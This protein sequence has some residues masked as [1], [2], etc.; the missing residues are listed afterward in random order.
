METLKM[1]KLA[2]RGYR[3][4]KTPEGHLVIHDVPIFVDCKRGDVE[5]D[6]VWVLQAVKAAQL[7]ADE[8]YLPP[9]H[10]YH[11]DS[12]PLVNSEVRAAGVIKVRGAEHIVFK[13][14]RRLA[15]MADLVVTDETVQDEVLAMKFPYRSVEILNINEP[16]INSLA[17]LDHQVPYLELPILQVKG[18]PMPGPSAV[19]SATF[20]MPLDKGAPDRSSPMV[21]CFQ[22]ELYTQVLFQ[23]IGSMGKK[24]DA[25]TPP[26]KFEGDPPKDDKPKDDKPKGEDMQ[27]DVLDVAAVVKAIKDK[28]ITVADMD[29]ILEAIADAKG[30]AEPAPE[31][32]EPAPA[33]V[34][35]G[36][37]M[38]KGGIP[39][40]LTGDAAALFAA[41]QAR[42]D[43]LEARHNDRDEKDAIKADV[44]LAF[45][46]LS[47]RPLGS[48]IKE[49]LVKFRQD[50]GAEAFKVYVDT[51]VDTF[52]SLEGNGTDAAARFQR[53]QVP[54]EAEKYQEDGPEAVDL[55]VKFAA[56]WDELNQAR[57]TS[58]SRERYIAVNMAR[59]AAS[60]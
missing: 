10:I 24:T 18:S 48:N 41:Q 26:A 39:M 36:E 56:E 31:D 25:T 9:L 22:R 14:T 17:L 33:A 15:I 43:A 13:G 57:M 12:D 3:A 49:R 32:T 16:G 28:S 1:A 58:M 44:D 46:K 5:F 2:H 37:A 40:K 34:P 4:T 35:G 6:E 27:D 45:A 50:H 21:A 52:D 55:A 11:H 42:I 53:R 30:P 23:E 51:L 59:R 54:K 38:Q 19:A 7:R 20:S 29:L 60:A 47:D 8:G